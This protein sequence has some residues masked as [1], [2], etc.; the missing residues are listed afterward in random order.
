MSMPYQ[1]VVM[2]LDLVNVMLHKLLHTGSWVVERQ[3]YMYARQEVVVI[4]V[5]VL[6]L[7]RMR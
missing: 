6:W 5:D 7:K 2:F 4:V 1:H 3:P